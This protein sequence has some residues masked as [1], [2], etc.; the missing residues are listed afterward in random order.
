M[1]VRLALWVS[2]LRETRAIHCQAS[3]QMKSTSRTATTRHRPQRK[4]LALAIQV[5]A[6]PLAFR[7]TYILSL[8]KLDPS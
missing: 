7:A 3:E 6:S 5:N 8:R 2:S 4:R 1:T